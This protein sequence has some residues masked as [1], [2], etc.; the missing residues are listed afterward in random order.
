MSF[1]LSLVVPAYNEEARLPGKL[2][3]LETWAE[4]GD[5]S[6]EVIVVDDGSED[7]TFELASR[8][9]ESHTSSPL[10]VRLFRIDHRGKGAAVRAGIRHVNGEV[11][12]YC[13][14][15]ASS[16]PDAIESVYKAVRI[17]A[18]MALASRTVPG[19]VLPVRQ[20]WY[21]EQAGHIF[22]F[23]FRK[24]AKVPF[25]DTQCGL[26]LFTRD[27]AREIF[28]HQRVDGFAFDT[29][30]VVLAIRLGYSV[31]EVPITWR[32]V[33][34]S[35]VSMARDSILMARDLAAIVRRTNRGEVHSPG[36]PNAATLEQ[37]VV[38]EENHWWHRAKRAVVVDALNR[39]DASGPCLD[40]GCGGGATLEE[41]S[42]TPS[43]GL[44]LSL[45]AL[46]YAN[47]KGI[48]GV[49]HA[50][51]GG[52]PF[53]SSSLGS[54]L[55]LDV[56]EHHPRP[57]E[58][59]REVHR[60]LR[61][62]G[63][64]V[65]TVPA[66]QWMWSYADHVL[67]HYRRYTRERLKKDLEN[68]GFT[69]ERITYFHSW[70]VAPVHSPKLRALRGPAETADDFPLPGPLNGVLAKVTKAE[71]RFLSKRNLPFGLSVLAV[72]R[73]ADTDAEAVK[74]ISA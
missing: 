68:S 9:I 18:D 16:G 23:I 2:D 43:F 20:P 22:N 74:P 58:M 28:R 55:A 65:I 29:E 44:D 11:V 15:D 72:G 21:R 32:H 42:M 69:V 12:G 45:D 57:E 54:A 36:V 67:G 39:S 61:P 53:A 26:K 6:L 38:G 10:A 62:G 27:A 64:V 17:G 60:A 5:K 59:L 40:I 35:K 8:W 70:L 31:E 13:D 24:L 7:S 25:R 49:V 51:A 63:V 56:V 47:Q 37:M 71:L 1:D 41:V 66:Y 52:L 33:E 48:D 14:A 73:R 4:A 3:E 46:A 19:A 30:L 50:E 34:G